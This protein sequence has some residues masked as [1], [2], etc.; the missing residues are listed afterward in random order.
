MEQVERVCSHN[1]A[2]FVFV[3][4]EWGFTCPEC[5]TLV[6]AET[7]EVARAGFEREAGPVLNHPASWAEMVSNG[8]GEPPTR[9]R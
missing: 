9:H 8:D 7:P 5:E 4:R 6:S 3:E 2:H 1:Q